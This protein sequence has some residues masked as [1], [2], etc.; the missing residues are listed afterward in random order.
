[1]GTVRYKLKALK[2]RSMR[3]PSLEWTKQF[4]VRLQGRF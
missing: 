4:R 1:M 3:M 2:G